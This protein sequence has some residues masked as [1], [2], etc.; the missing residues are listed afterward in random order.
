MCCRESKR[1]KMVKQ[2]KA[3]EMSIL[4]LKKGHVR[5]T[6]LFSVNNFNRS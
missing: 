1:K 5:L 4:P 3:S 6:C 2:E